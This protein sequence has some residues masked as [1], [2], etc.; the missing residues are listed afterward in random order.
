[1]SRGRVRNSKQQQTGLPEPLAADPLPLLPLPLAVTTVGYGDITPQSPKEKLIAIPLMV[2]GVVLVGYITSFVSAP[3]PLTL[4]PPHHPAP[5][6]ACIAD[7][8]AASPPPLSCM[9]R[10]R[11]AT[12]GRLLFPKAAACTG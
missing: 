6:P 3:P 8:F 5:A 11:C 4:P 9:H 12:P 10:R 1:M 2:T 7:P